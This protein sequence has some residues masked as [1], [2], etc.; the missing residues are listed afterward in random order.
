MKRKFF[1]L[2][3][4]FLVGGLVLAGC[5]PKPKPQPSEP[6]PVESTQVEPSTTPSPTPQPTPT[7]PPTS[8]LVT[9][10]VSV[11][12]ETEAVYVVGSFNEWDVE[13]PIELDKMS[14][15]NWNITI[16]LPFGDHQY[17][18]VNHTSWD[19]VEKDELGNEIDNRTFTLTSSGVVIDDVVQSWAITWE[20]IRYHIVRFFVDGAQYGKSIQVADGDSAPIPEDPIL[21]G[22]QFVKWDKSFDNIKSNTDFIAIFDAYPSV[23]LDGVSYPTLAEALLVAPDN[24]TIYLTEGN[25]HDPIHVTSNNLTIQSMRN[26]TPVITNVITLA[27]SVTSFIISGTEFTQ[28]ARIKAEGS[29]VGFV[30]EFNKVYDI[31]GSDEFGKLHEK[32]AIDAF[33]NL[34]TETATKIT[35]RVSN[36][37]FKNVGLTAI[38]IGNPAH[39]SNVIITNNDFIGVKDVAV[40]VDGETVDGTFNITRNVFDDRFANESLGSIL[41][42]KTGGTNKIEANIE[43]NMFYSIG[44]ISYE[45]THEVKSSA[46]IFHDAAEI[47]KLINIKNNS[48][49]LSANDI[50]IDNSQAL[51]TANIIENIFENTIGMF[52]TQTEYAN[53][54]NIKNSNMSQNLFM[55]NVDFREN[56]IMVNHSDISLKLYKYNSTTAPLNDEVGVWEKFYKL[57]FIER[58][59]L[60]VN[61][62]SLENG[63]T[64][65]LYDKTWIIGI[66]AF[67]TIQQAVNKATNGQTIQVQFG[68]YDEDITISKSLNIV[69]INRVRRGYH[70]SRASESIITGTITLATNFINITGF[71]FENGGRV[72]ARK[73]IRNVALINNIMTIENQGTVPHEEKGLINYIDLSGNNERIN[74]LGIIGNKI[75]G[76]GINAIDPSIYLVGVDGM[77]V[78]DNVIEGTLGTFLSLKKYNLVS[79]EELTGRVRIVGNK[80]SQNGIFIDI[81]TAKNA[82]IIIHNNEILESYYPMLSIGFAAGDTSGSSVH[83]EFKY[84][85]YYYI[86]FT[87]SNPIIFSGLEESL[88][89]MN[90]YYN[91]IES[92]R[93][94]Y[95]DVSHPSLGGEIKVIYNYFAEITDEIPYDKFINCTELDQFI[96]DLVWFPSYGGTH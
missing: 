64:F 72:I 47:T 59:L 96:E 45:T 20:P 14:N 88:V 24:A 4:L 89:T 36:S 27:E 30:F 95:I 48:F 19:Y 49:N 52:L 22:Y 62:P 38:S 6:T 90:F 16:N 51:F 85:R 60:V 8:M 71:K 15:N 43:R 37:E 86:Q 83:I 74:H 42:T 35:A 12:E 55:G 70:P 81:G 34:H 91:L 40:R 28:N 67:T 53:S 58:D 73:G 39:Q 31:V 41:F 23:L 92:T 75:V 46:I 21:E 10:S 11:P 69:G 33:I 79:E 13:N 50:H 5:K 29:L 66:N 18:Y 7:P 78:L 56:E 80:S 68:T 1:V 82:E 76:N 25:Y 57:E 32:G 2:T 77:S 54:M 87:A 9:F 44:S 84:N 93:G 65:E 26:H 17:K 63:Y 61:N 3:F 94:K